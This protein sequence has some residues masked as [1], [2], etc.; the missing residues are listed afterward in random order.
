MECAR[1]RGR[2][3][4]MTDLDGTLAELSRL[5]SGSEPIV[6]LYLDVR[7]RD[8]QRREQVRLFVRR[9]LA[10]SWG[11]TPKA[12]P[13]GRAR[14]DAREG[15]RA[16]GGPH[17]AGVRGGARRARPLRVRDARAVAAALLR[18]TVRRGALRRRH[19]AP[20]PARPARRRGDAG[21]RG[22]ALEGGRGRVRGAAR[23]GRD[24]GERRRAAA[25][26][27]LREAQRGTG[28]PGAPPRA[29]GEERAAHG[30]VGSA[31]PPGGCGRG[32]GAL[33][34]DAAGA[35]HPRRPD[36]DPLGVRARPAGAGSGGHR[37][38]RPEAARVGLRGRGPQ[39]RG[40]GAR[41]DG[42]R[43]RA[44]RGAERGGRGGRRGAPRRRRR[45]SAPRTWC[46]P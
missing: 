22:R 8:E 6:S 37:R 41:G 38:A 17:H 16:R 30:G 31:E 2:T 43:A 27:R 26:E 7:W 33:R 13:A 34:P 39:G 11:T 45:S 21:D 32:D 23:R 46:S 15:D 10:R 9:D 29:R 44:E 3:G 35:D 1:S 19:P 5:R 40:A 25:A 24:R 36:A 28:R 14:A 4:K 42:A 12:R 18:A 20:R